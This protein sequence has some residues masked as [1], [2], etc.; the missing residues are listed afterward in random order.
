VVGNPAQ[1]AQEFALP[2]Y[3]HRR[4]FVQREDHDIA[5]LFFLIAFHLI[6]N[7]FHRDPASP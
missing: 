2:M 6:P 1:S 4:G 5:V 7:G 3:E